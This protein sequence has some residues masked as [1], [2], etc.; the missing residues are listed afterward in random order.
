MGNV[1]H[2]LIIKLANSTLD[3]EMI[4]VGGVKHLHTFM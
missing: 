1:D 2:H 3:T 4:F